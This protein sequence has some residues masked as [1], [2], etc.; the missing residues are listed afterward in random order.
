MNSDS[1]FRLQTVLTVREYQ[2]RR[3]Q[4]DLFKIGQEKERESGVLTQ[5]NDEIELAVFEDS[6]IVRARATELQTSK[7]FIDTLS[8]KITDQEQVIGEL[9]HK[10]EH[11]RVE[12]VSKRQSRHMLESLKK[13]HEEKVQ[14]EEDL[15]MQKIIDEF[16]NRE[17]R[18]IGE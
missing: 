14:K 17:R 2:E 3:L 10:E 18:K 16:G 7:A 9:T 12:L 15:K 1:Q 6:T 8:N 4:H 5:L 13:T 11:T